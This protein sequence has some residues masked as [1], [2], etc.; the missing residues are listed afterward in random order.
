[1]SQAW[2][3]DFTF[4]L[5]TLQFQKVQKIPLQFG[6][7][8]EAQERNL[9]HRFQYQIPVSVW[10]VNEN[11]EILDASYLSRY[12]H[13][14]TVLIKKVE[15]PKCILL[16]FETASTLKIQARFLPTGSHFVSTINWTMDT[17]LLRVWKQKLPYILL[18]RAVSK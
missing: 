18:A 12:L 10:N 5:I 16:Q 15:H 2:T 3:Q 11:K 7:S 4:S 17:Q 1:M 13:R 8:Q 9:W 6:L 14:L